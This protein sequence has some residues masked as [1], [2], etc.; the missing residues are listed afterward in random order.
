MTDAAEASPQSVRRGALFD[1]RGEVHAGPLTAHR[2]EG[3]QAG[4]WGV[5]S[6]GLV[7]GQNQ[8]CFAIGLGGRLLIVAD[9]LG[10][11]SS[12][13]V[14]STWAVETVADTV[15]E[16]I[17]GGASEAGLLLE[18]IDHAQ[19][20]L[21]RAAMFE[22]GFRGMGTGLVAGLVGNDRLH[23]CHVGDVRAYLFREGKLSRLT[24]D[25]S[26]VQQLLDRG[27]IRPEE[28]WNHPLRNRV[29]QAVGLVPNFDPSQ[30]EV[31]LVAGDRLLL[32]S[33]GLWGTLPESG[34]VA[35]FRDNESVR[36]AAVEM[37]AGANASGGPDNITV[38][39]YEHA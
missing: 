7:R 13:E 3:G 1:D 34:I 23:L 12:G 33:D 17:A 2:G 6:V 22:A 37:V 9:G 5:T 25:H 16:R 8:D 24:R 32:C 20:R 39:A 26:A 21:C 35:A 38:V 19:K 27:E 14:A 4:A 18:G 11:H 29:L 30:A 31:P 15:L 36:D 10:G 28:A